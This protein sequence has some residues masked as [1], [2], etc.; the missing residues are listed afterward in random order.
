[1]APV[2]IEPP[3]SV[4][5]SPA[6]VAHLAKLKPIFDGK[7]LAGWIQAPVA[8]IRFAGEDQKDFPALAKKLAEKSDP[9]AAF[10]NAQLDEAGRAALAIYSPAADAKVNAPHVS[11]IMRNINRLVG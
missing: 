7:S 10:L 5:L 4:P 11:A 8:P 9:V 1:T 3:P 2:Y 6:V